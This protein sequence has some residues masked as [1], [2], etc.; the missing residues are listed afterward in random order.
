MIPVSKPWITKLEKKYL[1]EV[2]NTEWI[3]SGNFVE[4]FENSFSEYVGTKFAISTCNGT[5]ACHLALLSSGVNK[6]DEIIVPGSTFIATANSVAYCGA[7]IKLVDIDPKTWNMDCSLL[8]KSINKSTKAVFYV[9]LYGNIS[10]MDLV[11]K[12]CKDAIL[13]EDACE[14]IGGEWKGKK[15]GA[16]GKA[17]AFS[18][19]ANKTISTG[20][21]GMV[22]TNDEE[23]AHKARLLRGQGQTSRYFHTTIGYN[24][25]MTD[26]QASLGLAQI[27]RIDEILEEKNRVYNRY[28]KNIDNIY[29]AEQHKFSKHSCWAI[30]ILC[31]DPVEL[32][33][34]LKE[35]EID[36]RR[37]F[38]SISSLPPYSNLTKCPN[39]E[40][41][42]NHGI[43]LPSY[44]TLNNKQIDF[45]CDI[46]NKHNNDWSPINVYG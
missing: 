28:K 3:S 14:A 10:D 18:F 13:I 4:K 19:Y 31:K 30:T 9:Y 44:P 45:I 20:E 32:E 5:T 22:L 35:N 24:Y 27:Q 36:S 11:Q 16:I 41:L 2:I 40:Y 46:V 26:L 43:T 15:A 33:K 29:M 21:G 34:I 23:I 42:S 39:S 38:Y 25:R 37:A 17:S 1:S 12:L 8:D 6:E 7:K